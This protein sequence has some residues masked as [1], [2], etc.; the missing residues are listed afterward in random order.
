MEQ[1]NPLLEQ[2]NIK[3][4]YVKFLWTKCKICEQEF[5]KTN[6]WFYTHPYPRNGQYFKFSVCCDCIQSYD[7]LVDYIFRKPN[8]PQ[9]VK[10]HLITDSGKEINIVGLSLK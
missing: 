3:I 9:R 8:V 7:K 6:M 2:C 4:K 5:R 1:R 10:G